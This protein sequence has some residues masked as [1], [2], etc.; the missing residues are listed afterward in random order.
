M[1]STTDRAELEAI[2]IEAFTYLYPLVLMN[3]TVRQL[4]NVERVGQAPLHAPIG[5]FVHVPA[6]P[7]GDFKGV[8]RPNFDTLYSSAFVRLDEPVILSVPDAGDNYYLLPMYDMF[9]EVFASPGT[10]TT[11]NGAQQIAILPP[12]WAGDLPDGVRRIRAPHALM[13]IIG[14]T[15]ASP[16]TYG[17]V[18]AFQAGLTLTPLSA[19]PGSAPE[20]VGT[21][22]PDVDMVTP[23]LTQVF[24][25]DAPAFFAEATGLLA[26]YPSRLF[27][28]TILMRLQQ[29]GIV[30]GEVLDVAALDPDVQAALAAAVPAAQARITARQKSLGIE[31]NGWRITFEN[32][33]SYGQDYL[34]RATVELIGLGANLCDD[35]IYPVSYVDAD[36]RPYSGEHAYVLH[37]EADQLP[38]ARAFWSVTLYDDEGFQVPN[39][40]NRFAIGDRDALRF[41]ADGSL[42][43]H[44]QATAPG[45]DRDSN[46]LPAPTGSFNL[47]LRIYYPA[48]SA[49]EGSWS[50]P[51]VRR[52]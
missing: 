28:Q 20:V 15:E 48:L 49:L 13:W 47:C 10:R 35:A 14:R 2:G 16:A 31:A 22:D 38:P 9:G 51:A 42:D 50:P 26:Q 6:F 11:G 1:G 27:D 37:F 7:P 33:G 23:P 39:A 36:G 8:V 34:Q 21:V 45:G 3:R 41:G 18:H 25:L 17:A 19:W 52:V 46:W 12:G 43:L 30:E 40:L 32:M 24:D 44:I 5:A 4:S 29:V